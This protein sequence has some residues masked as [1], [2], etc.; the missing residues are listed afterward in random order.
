VRFNFIGMPPKLPPDVNKLYGV[1][2]D[3]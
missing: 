2:L 1:T 3:R